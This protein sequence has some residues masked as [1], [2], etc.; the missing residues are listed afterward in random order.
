MLLD[1]QVRVKRRELMRVAVLPH[2]RI[3]LALGSDFEESLRRRD[4]ATLPGVARLNSHQHVR[5]MRVPRL[6]SPEIALSLVNKALA[7][8][9]HLPR[10]GVPVVRV[11][12]AALG[13]VG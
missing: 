1:V 9:A 5:M 8:P 6:G 11:V 3:D 4:D 12:Q 7:A 10:L 2:A 13:G